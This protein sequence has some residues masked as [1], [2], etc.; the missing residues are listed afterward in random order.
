MYSYVEANPKHH[1]HASADGAHM[2]HAA[3]SMRADPLTALVIGGISW[4]LSKLS[5]KPHNEWKC[6]YCNI[7]FN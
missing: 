7:E 6:T 4:G 3:H 5:E 2:A 1:S